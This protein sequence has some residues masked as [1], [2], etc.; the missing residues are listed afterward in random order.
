MLVF[1]VIFLFISLQSSCTFHLGSAERT[2]P[3]LAAH[4]FPYMFRLMAMSRSSSGRRTLNALVNAE[5]F[6]GAGFAVSTFF[7]SG[8]E[9]PLCMHA[10]HIVGRMQSMILDDPAGMTTC[11]SSQL[12]LYLFCA[13]SLAYLE[14]P[15]QISLQESFRRV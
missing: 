13:S 2:A 6:A 7:C 11:P 15:N 4:F 8:A 14:L 1:T 12:G 5:V 10:Q 9:S 3:P